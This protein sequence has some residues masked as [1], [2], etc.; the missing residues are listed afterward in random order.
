MYNDFIKFI[1]FQKFFLEK[2]NKEQ[3][4]H[5]LNVH[6]ISSVDF[7]CMYRLIHI[8]ETKD[9][10]LKVSSTSTAR[11]HVSIQQLNMIWS[12]VLTD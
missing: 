8:H 2:R 3:I 1:S 12:S 5:P 11:L 9:Q 6:D 4:K 10:M 7:N